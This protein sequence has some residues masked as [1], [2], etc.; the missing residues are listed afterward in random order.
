MLAIMLLMNIVQLLAAQRIL[1]PQVINSRVVDSCVPQD[2]R[3]LA[4]QNLSQSVDSI[5]A[6][7]ES[8]PC[9]LGLWTRVAN[10]KKNMLILHSLILIVVY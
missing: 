3:D 4:Q 2:M 6:D 8:H 7:I 5:I 10:C 9:G 1:N